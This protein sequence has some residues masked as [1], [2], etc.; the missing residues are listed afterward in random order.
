[1]KRVDVIIVCDHLGKFEAA[2]RRISY[3]IKYLQSKNLRTVCVGPISI[4]SYGIVKPPKECI[5]ISL[6]ILS[7]NI[8][9]HLFNVVLSLP[10][11]I[12]FL[13]L[14]PKVVIVSVPDS[15]LVIP[16]YLGCILTRA[17][18]VIDI[19]DP[20]EEIL[21]RDWHSQK[22]FSH[23]LS[24][25]YR[26]INYTIYRRCHAVIGVTRSLVTMMA[27]QIGRSVI[28][29]PNGADL[30]AFT[31][32]DKYEARKKL[33]LCEDCFLI[34]YIGLLS[35]RSYYNILPLLR[36][37]KEIRR[38]LGLNIKLLMAGPLYDDYVKKIIR[39]FKDEIIYL[40]LLNE[41]KDVVTLL[42]ACDIGIV[43]RA[44]NPIYD[45]ALPI[46]FYEYIA[47]G[48]PLIVIASKES[49]L[50]RIVETYKL[51]LV[52]EPYDV[53]CLEIALIEVITNRRS[54]EYL[55]VNVMSFRKFVDRKIGAKILFKL[56]KGLIHQ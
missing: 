55:R 49:E 12:L 11:I 21:I 40:G 30:D 24:R 13:L 5:T 56:I 37:I 54:L 4:A 48:L 45:Y 35:T 19:R 27:R 1:M 38:S 34:A 46:K 26:L 20:Q 53:D 3:F 14:Q 41:E 6:S 29:V 25:I 28:L 23:L 17:K 44:N 9:A 2:Y 22:S 10:L 7:R 51:G 43:P 31:P 15:F 32:L 8:V 16:S 18:L 42:S 50:A 36:S 33:G 39:Y 47:T 52:C